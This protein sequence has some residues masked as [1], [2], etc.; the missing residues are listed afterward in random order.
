MAPA[1][2]PRA[3]HE[4]FTLY[5]LDQL[6]AYAGAEGRAMFGGVGLYQDGAM[7]GIIFKRRLYFRVSPDTV[8]AY[9]ARRMKAFSP[10]PGKTMTAYREVPLSVLEDA[11]DLVAWA[12]KRPCADRAG[13]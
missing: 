1:G 2:K 7:F 6:R 4:P 3:T 13:V 9:T 8:G 11:D 12:Q 5:V 10:Y